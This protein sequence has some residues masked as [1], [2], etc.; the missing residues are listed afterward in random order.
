MKRGVLCSLAPCGG[1]RVA[2]PI[3]LAL[4]AADSAGAQARSADFQAW[5]PARAG[6]ENPEQLEPVPHLAEAARSARPPA[7]AITLGMAG[8]VGSAAGVFGGG[9]VGY[10]IDRAD[11]ECGDDWCGFGGLFLGAAI[12]SAVLAPVAV[13]M[14]NGGRGDLANSMFTSAVITGAGA[15]LALVTNSAEVLVAVPVAAIISSVALERAST[16]SE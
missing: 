4:L 7:D 9:Y 16:P 15:V 5:E 1:M 6:W 10:H 3:M 12:G 2:L 13:H 11:G 14:A 8:L